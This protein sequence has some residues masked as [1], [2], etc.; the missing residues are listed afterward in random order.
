MQEVDR[1]KVSL[2]RMQ[3]SRLMSEQILQIASSNLVA[4]HL[5]AGFDCFTHIP[6]SCMGK[7][8]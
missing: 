7:G 2:C 5:P 6:T 4:S 8:C 1:A 3:V